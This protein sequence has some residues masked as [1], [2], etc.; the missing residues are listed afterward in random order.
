MGDL[1]CFVRMDMEK[2]FAAPQ[3]TGGAGLEEFGLGDVWHEIL[4]L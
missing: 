1:I 2:Q 4:L 3:V